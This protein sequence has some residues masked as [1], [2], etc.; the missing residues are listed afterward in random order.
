MSDTQIT[1]LSGLDIAPDPQNKNNGFYAPGLTTAQ[2][3]AIPGDTIRNGGIIYNTEQNTFQTYAQ[4]T[5]N[6]LASYRTG[7]ITDIGDINTAA[8]PNL[9]CTG[10]IISAAKADSADNGNLI[11]INYADLGYIPFIF[12]SVIDSSV[13]KMAQLVVR[14][15]ATASQAVFFLEEIDEAVQD[16]KVQILLLQPNL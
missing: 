16:V 7:A 3:D 12:I 9:T 8:N 13:S 5:W 10:A 15:N 2:R 11:T 14:P 1:K 4:G 6:N